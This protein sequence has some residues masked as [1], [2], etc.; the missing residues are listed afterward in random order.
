MEAKTFIILLTIGVA[1]FLWSYF[2]N[3]PKVI[4]F[5]HGVL[6][7]LDITKKPTCGDC[8]LIQDC[9]IHNMNQTACK[10]L[11]EWEDM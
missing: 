6:E 4:A 3:H 5:G 1:G 2:R 10:R 8:R 9:N 7:A 11:D